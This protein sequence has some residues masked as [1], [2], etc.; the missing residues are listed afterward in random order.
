MKK[1]QS[2]PGPAEKKW[3]RGKVKCYWAQNFH[4]RFHMALN[5]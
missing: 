2:K 3:T 1:G 4:M 5:G